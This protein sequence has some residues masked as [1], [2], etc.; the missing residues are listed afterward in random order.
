MG[1]YTLLGRAKLRSTS[2]YA[3][4]VMMVDS[5]GDGWVSEGSMG[6]RIEKVR[7]SRSRA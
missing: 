4:P 1:V 6:E 3:V 5:E 7:R 2:K